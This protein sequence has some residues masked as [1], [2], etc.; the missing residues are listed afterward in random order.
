MSSEY[1][2]VERRRLLNNVVSHYEIPSW[3]DDT[4]LLDFL[5]V[6]G[7]TVLTFV[8]ERPQSKIQLSLICEMMRTDPVTANIVAV[9][10]STFNSYQESVYDSVDLEAMYERMVT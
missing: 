6:I 4:S 9:E 5:N 2:V 1:R 8:R 3:N 10:R 7:T